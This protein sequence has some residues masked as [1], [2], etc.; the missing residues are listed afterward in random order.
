MKFRLHSLAA[1]SMMAA[2]ALAAGKDDRVYEL[3]VYYSPEG[4]LDALSARFRDHTTKL[5]EKHGMTN[6]GYWTPIENPDRKLIYVLAYPSREAAKKSWTAFLADPDWQ[7]AH[8]ESERDGRLVSKIESTFLTATDY[9]PEIKP[10]A[11]GDRVFEL[12]TYTTTPGNLDRLHKRFRDHTTKLFEK[13]GMTNV[14]Y[15]S[16]VKSDKRS[17]NTLVYLLAHKSVDAAKA[18]FDAF[19]KDGDWIKAKGESE[20]EAGGSLTAQDGVK[21]EFLKATDYSPVR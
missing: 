1:L 15:W 5:F 9:S 20:K 10:A 4:K 13:H 6:V 3:R 14:A 17:D 21:S 19:R 2:S 12:R 18:S 16:P 7:K 11:S 8:R